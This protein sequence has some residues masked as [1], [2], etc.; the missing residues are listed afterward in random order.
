LKDAVMQMKRWEEASGL[1]MSQIISEIA[2]S[3]AQKIGSHIVGTLLQHQKSAIKY[4]TELEETI[5]KTNAEILDKER[6]IKL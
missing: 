2:A 3:E 1:I 6:F 5:K 4:V